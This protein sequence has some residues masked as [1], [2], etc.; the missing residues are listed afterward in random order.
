MGFPLPYRLVN[1]GVFVHQHQEYQQVSMTHMF[2]IGL[3][4]KKLFQCHCFVMDDIMARYMSQN[5]ANQSSPILLCNLQKVPT[6]EIYHHSFPPP[7]PQK[8]KRQFY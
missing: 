2:G 4:W 1:A 7:P 5:D 3:D 6:V 8:K